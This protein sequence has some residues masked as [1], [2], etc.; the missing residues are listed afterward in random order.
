MTDTTVNKE[1]GDKAKT[2]KGGMSIR[3]L[4]AIAI[5]IAIVLAFYA[6]AMASQVADAASTAEEDQNRYLECSS[7]T[8]ELQ[9]ASDY[10][11]TQAR[12]FI[13]TGD[14]T[15]MDN[16]LEEL[17]AINRRGKAVEQLK[18]ILNDQ[19]AS[20]ELETAL[21][22]SD[23]LAQKELYALRLACEAYNIGDVPDK[24]ASVSLSGS[25]TDKS[26]SEKLERAR[27]L[28]IGLEYDTSKLEIQQQ[29]DASSTSLLQD[30]NASREASS[31]RLQSLL[32]QLRIAVALLLCVIMLL[33]LT[34][35]LYV[36]KPLTR[37]INRIETGHSL[38]P[39][40]SYE[41]KYLA[42]AYNTVYEYNSQRITN[43]RD[44]A[45][46]DPLT[47][48]SNRGGY[49]KFLSTHTRDIALLLI[50]VDDFKGFNDA[51]GHDVGDALLK[52][53]ARSLT[54]A[55][56]STDFPCRIGGDE[57]AVIM[58]NMNPGLRR[59]VRNKVGLVNTMLADDSDDLPLVTLSVGVAFSDEGMND[60]DIYRAADEALYRVKEHGR[61]GIAFADE[62][63]MVTA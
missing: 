5:V 13:V 12:T 8:N 39:Q 56:R 32:F 47:G 50:D 40:G 58:T 46:R 41:L 60:E 49:D 42:N 16:Y 3:I 21:S 17:L 24:V 45:E 31:A 11:T 10:L 37:Y 44:A 14:R 20:L 29:V 22:Y 34:V 27:A 55:F 38:E 23:D 43:L 57:F 62:G 19:T 15:Y 61:N 7:A 9:K 52:K 48:I 1:S 63:N 59:A 2:T 54:T 18:S 25:D 35:V 26:D 53:I 51:Y 4:G 36:L 30:L 33:V 6:F 28:V